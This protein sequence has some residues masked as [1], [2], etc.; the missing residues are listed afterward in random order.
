MINI[1]CLHQAINARDIYKVLFIL[2]TEQ[3]LGTFYDTKKFWRFLSEVCIA[4][5]VKLTVQF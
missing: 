4:A 1:G 2:R 3:D 5:V